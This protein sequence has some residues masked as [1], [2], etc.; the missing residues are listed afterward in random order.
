[1]R[2]LRT[3]LIIL[4]LLALAMVPILTKEN[5]VAKEQHGWNLIL[6]NDQYYIP[7]NYTVKLATL[8][9]GERV[10]S[11]IVSALNDMF[12]AAEKEDIYMVVASGYRTGEEQQ[13]MLDEK[14][15]EYKEKVFWEPVAKR[16]AK[17]WVA[18]PGTS[19]HQL[20]IAV[21]I[22]ADA[23]NSSGTEVYEWLA[24]HA[25]EYGFVQRYPSDKADITGINYEPWHYR[26]V[27]KDAAKTMVEKNLCLEEYVESL[28]RK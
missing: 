24:K 27:G 2:K 6:V 10:D 28:E 14:V 13:S 26:Y 23:V 16:M 9:N 18:I 17:K 15:E 20:G 25:Y 8:E 4:V 12:E 3:A 21:D 5:Q 11:R 22:N 7:N 19:E 1:M